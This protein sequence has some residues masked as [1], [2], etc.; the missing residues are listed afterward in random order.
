MKL[1]KEL[2]KRYIVWVRIGPVLRC[3]WVMQRIVSLVPR[4]RLKSLKTCGPSSDCPAERTCLYSHIARMGGMACC[5]RESTRV[6]QQAEAAK[7][8]CGQEP[9]RGFCRKN[10][11]LEVARLRVGQVE[12]FQQAVGHGGCPWLSATWPWDG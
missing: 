6:H 7:G 8:K 10:K 4:V 12:Y 11:S 2:F 1:A 9:S 5:T 3:E